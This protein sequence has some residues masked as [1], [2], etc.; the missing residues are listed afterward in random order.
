MS[1]RRIRQRESFLDI[2]IS[3]VLG[4]LFLIIIIFLVVSNVKINKRKKELNERIS[5]LK[6]EIKVLQER[7]NE[8]KAGIEESHQSDYIEKILRQKG[9][10]KKEGEKVVVILPPKEEKKEIQKEEKSIWE[11]FLE[12]FKLRD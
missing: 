2:S 11:R 5:Q 12:L 9:L 8:L 3:V 1:K 4:I 6:Q 7:N 10:Y